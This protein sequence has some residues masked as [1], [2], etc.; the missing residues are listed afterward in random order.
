[1]LSRMD[2]NR[3]RKKIKFTLLFLKFTRENF[4]WNPRDLF[5][6]NCYKKALVSL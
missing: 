3:T 5:L 4:S 1:M 2:E 6:L